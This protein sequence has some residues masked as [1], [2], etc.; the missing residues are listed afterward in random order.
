MANIGELYDIEEGRDFRTLR[1]LYGGDNEKRTYDNKIVKS[2]EELVIANYLFA[3]QIDYEYEKVFECTNKY[4]NSQKEFIYK[5]IFKNLDEITNNPMLDDLLSNLYDSCEIKEHIIVKDHVPD[6]YIKENEIYLEHFGVNRNCEALWL[7][8][9]G[10]DKY[11]KGIEWKRKLHK[12]YGSTLIETY[13]FYMA[14]DCLLSKL[15]ENLKMQGLKLK[16]LIMNTYF[17]KLLKEIQLI[18]LSIS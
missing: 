13:S 14:E 18:N 5:L 12:K 15:E 11:K 7:D 4:Y 1:D 3:H 16:K 10:S 8:K 2:F 6:F 17:Q 9:E